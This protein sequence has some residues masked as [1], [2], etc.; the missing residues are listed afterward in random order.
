MESEASR[1]NLQGLGRYGG[2]GDEEEED[3]NCGFND[4]SRKFKIYILVKVRK[5]V[6][7]NLI[8]KIM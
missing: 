7:S 5:N 8:K 3:N 4:Y 1:E 6:F 2:G